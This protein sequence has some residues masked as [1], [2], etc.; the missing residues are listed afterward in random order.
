MSDDQNYVQ[1]VKRVSPETETR[2]TFPS[3]DEL[4]NNRI[5]A[6]K[7]MRQS[8]QFKWAMFITELQVYRRR[9]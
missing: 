2:F 6:R 1:E 4:A 5:E 8:S 3:Q 9:A 7:T